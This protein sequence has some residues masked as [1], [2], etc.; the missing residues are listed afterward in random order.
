MLLYYLMVSKQ[1]IKNFSKKHQGGV[2]LKLRILF[3]IS[4]NFRKFDTGL[5]QG[6][7][8]KLIKISRA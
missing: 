4:A 7:G 6:L 3:C 1:N 8:E 5:M 2:H